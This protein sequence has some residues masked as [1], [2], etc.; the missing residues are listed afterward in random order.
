MGYLHCKRL[1]SELLGEIPPTKFL[2]TLRHI[3]Q[4]F[5]PLNLLVPPADIFIATTQQIATDSITDYYVHVA[6]RT[7]LW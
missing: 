3:W 4:L 1:V 7:V 6:S 2:K 5:H